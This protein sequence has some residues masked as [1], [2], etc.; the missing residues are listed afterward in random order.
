MFTSKDQA[1][2]HFMNMDCLSTFD[3]YISINH[4]ELKLLTIAIRIT[5]CI[6]N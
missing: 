4:H 5:T 6:S 2:H 3:H 1:L